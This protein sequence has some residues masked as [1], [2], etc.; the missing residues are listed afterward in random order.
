MIASNALRLSVLGTVLLLFFGTG[1]V[2]AQDGKVSKTRKKADYYYA[3]D[4]LV[5]AEELY[6]EVVNQAP[7]DYRATYRLGTINNFLQDYREALRYFRKAAEIDP[8]RND[9]VFLQ[10]GLAYKRLNDYRKARES[11]EEFM[12]RH[13]SRDEL[14]ELAELEVKGCDLAES[15]LLQE[16]KEY[17]V[18]PASFNSTARDLFP[19]YLDQRQETNSWFIPLTVQDRRKNEDEKSWTP[20]PVNPK[21]RICTTS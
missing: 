18:N 16:Y 4:N 21:T 3:E 7:N 17:R 20:V 14:Y 1:Y 6:K 10:I 13:R 5:E 8:M 15:S 19:A 11:F 9:T 2:Q 12:R